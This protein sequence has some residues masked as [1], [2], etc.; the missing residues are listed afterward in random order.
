MMKTCIQK[1]SIHSICA[2]AVHAHQN[3]CSNAIR[4]ELSDSHWFC[5]FHAC[6]PDAKLA[7]FRALQCCQ[8]LAHSFNLHAF[9]YVQILNI[10]GSATCNQYHASRIYVFIIACKNV[11]DIT[12]DFLKYHNELDYRVM[13]A[14]V[15]RFHPR[16]S[17]VYEWYVKHKHVLTWSRTYLIQP[18]DTLTV[19][20]HNEVPSLK[21]L[22]WIYDIETMKL[23]QWI[24]YNIWSKWDINGNYSLR[25]Q[26]QY[27]C[28]YLFSPCDWSMSSME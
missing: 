20:R 10:N 21:W 13:H 14:S 9:N 19:D 2:A 16:C 28:V 24:Y 11:M 12:R 26:F 8:N 5:I 18:R 3:P 17:Y 7:F 15:I 22:T 6:T 23:K 4:S 27:M 25:N 1:Y